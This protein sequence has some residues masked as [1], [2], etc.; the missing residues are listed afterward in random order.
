MDLRGATRG[1]R[2][3]VPDD[4]AE[5]TRLRG[6]MYESWG[7]DAASGEWAQASIA[8]MRRA[9]A[10]DELVAFVVDGTDGLVS[11]GIGWVE[12]HLP[13][14]NNLS[15]LRGHIANMSTEPGHRRNGHARAVFE[16]LLA[17]FEERGVTR[18]DLRATTDGEPLYRSYGFTDPHD[19]PLTLRR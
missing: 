2:R 8:Y 4:A 11:C 17:W 1:V 15:G 12:Q 16:A 6:V 13:G 18:I 19:V 14:P 3:A 5:L 9:L 10:T 7:G